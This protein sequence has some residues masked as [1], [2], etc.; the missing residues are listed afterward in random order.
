[1]TQVISFILKEGKTNE[2]LILL[3]FSSYVEMFGWRIES[4]HCPSY[5]VYIKLLELCSDLDEGRL[6]MDL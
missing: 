1:M 5:Q 2:D 4:L 3:G 6:S